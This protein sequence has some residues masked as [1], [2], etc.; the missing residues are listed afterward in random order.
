MMETMPSG[1][2]RVIA[3]LVGAWGVASLQSARADSPPKSVPVLSAAETVLPVSKLVPTGYYGQVT[4]ESGKSA[5]P[6]LRI[7]NQDQIKVMSR[8]RVDETTRKKTLE[9]WAVIFGELDQRGWNLVWTDDSSAALNVAPR[10]GFIRAL[11]VRGRTMPFELVAVGPKGETI[12]EGWVLSFYDFD[13]AVREARTGK[14]RSRFTANAGVS[15]S[16]LSYAQ[17][18]VAGF[19]QIAVTAKGA[20]TYYF[21]PSRWDLGL[22]A[23]FTALPLSTNISGTSAR[24]IGVNFRVG[25][26]TPWL[27]DPWRLNLLAGGYYAS[28]FVSGSLFG[29][30]NLSGPQLFP[31]L[32][33]SLGGGD[34]L[35]FYG[36]FSP[37]TDGAQLLSLSNREIAGG[38]TWLHPLQGRHSIA[39]SLDASQLRFSSADTT[40]QST[41][42]SLGASYGW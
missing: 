24:F 19:S 35:I 33:R 13:A 21:L 42:L 36:K 14:P 39:G 31:T 4:L 40:I 20:M 16:T 37:V 7:V 27:H 29:Y 18:G 11:R 6:N 26:S 25:Y 3:A 1:S 9:I 10:S 28:M 17:T 5:I 30:R 22:S 32:S 41:S 12:R 2:A 23:Y 15:V 38:A 8:V 34:S